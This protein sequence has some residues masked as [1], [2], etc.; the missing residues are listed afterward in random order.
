VQDRDPFKFPRADG[1]VRAH[2]GV[3]FPCGYAE[4]A[5]PLPGRGRRL[6]FVAERSVHK[7]TEHCRRLAARS[8]AEGPV[9]GNVPSR[10][11]LL[12]SSFAAAS[13][14]SSRPTHGH[15]A[16]AAGSSHN[17]FIV[18]HLHCQF[19]IKAVLQDCMRHTGCL[20]IL[21]AFIVVP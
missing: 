1:F 4:F 20:Q 3:H 7:G 10:G 15:F 9:I 14:T 6:I 2:P 16:S 11:L 21:L 8:R 17:T 12:A 19:G 5:A 13:A 18:E